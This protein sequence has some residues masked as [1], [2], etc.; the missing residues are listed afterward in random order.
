[1]SQGEKVSG[2]RV[3]QVDL[4]ER[5]LIISGED[6]E[7]TDPEGN[8]QALSR[9]SRSRVTSRGSSRP[10]SAPRSRG[11][12]AGGRGAGKGGKRGGGLANHHMSWGR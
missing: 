3:H 1:M 5:K 10:R 6:L 9:R 11:E 7:L 8:A 2:L 12:K 4:V